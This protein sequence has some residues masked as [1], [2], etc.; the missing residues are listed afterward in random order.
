MTRLLE[1]AVE[2]VEELPPDEQD[3]IAALILDELQDKLGWGEALARSQD[4]PAPFVDEAPGEIRLRHASDTNSEE[5]VTVERTFD[6]YRLARL[7]S[8]PCA[9]RCC[10]TSRRGTPSRCGGT[11]G[12]SGSSRRTFR[13]TGRKTARRSN[14]CNA[15]SQNDLAQAGQF[16]R[17]RDPFRRDLEAYLRQLGSH[18]EGVEISLGLS[19]FYLRL[20][21][22]DLPCTEV[23]LRDRETTPP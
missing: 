13:W 23:Y 2:A 12:S 15:F 1:Q 10:G 4:E 22:V 17:G 19:E 5:L 18:L 9:R 16:L 20:R 11:G 14:D 8:S 3:A 21:E 7:C 6:P